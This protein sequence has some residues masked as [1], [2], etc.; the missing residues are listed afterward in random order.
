L[1]S[2]A[3]NAAGEAH[4]LDLD[5]AL[6]GGEVVVEPARVLWQGVD[7]TR[8]DAVLVERPVFA[9]P[10][11]TI[12]KGSSPLASER[13]AR[14]LTLSALYAAAETT[15][16]V[17]RPHSAH[18]AVAPLS[19]LDACARAGLAVRAWKSVD[20]LDDSS[21]ARVWL[22]PAG[23]DLWYE[24][25]SP[26]R[27]EPAWSPEPF[28]GAVLS[29]LVVGRQVAAAR[30]F[31]DAHAWRERDALPSAQPVASPAARE[32]ALRATL[33]LEL[34]WLQVDLL[35]VDGGAQLLS[36]AAGPDLSA[37]DRDSNGAIAAALGSLLDDEVRSR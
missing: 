4:F 8:A 28:D 6:R 35:E 17:Q 25:Q 21:D 14:A 26:T 20:A 15:A 16:V 13:E 32:L 9:W 27:G 22:D 37:W 24:P 23:A 31:A 36:V 19:A 1:E 33:A 29:L 18:L 30:R 11:P 12:V 34:S 7:L 2:I 5:A 10:Q 3:Q